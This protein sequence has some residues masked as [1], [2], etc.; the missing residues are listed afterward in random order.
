[1]HCNATATAVE[2]EEHNAILN[3]GH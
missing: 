2:V 3:E 1:M